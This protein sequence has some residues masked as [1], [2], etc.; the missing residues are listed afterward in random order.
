MDISQGKVF[1]SPEAGTY[2]G[3][4]IDVIDKPNVSTEWGLKNKVLIKWVITL[5]NGAPYLDPEGQ[6][7]TVSAYVT[8]MMSDRSS[9][10][11]F[12]NLYKIIVGILG[13]Q[14]PL[15]TSTQQLEQLLLNR[16][17]VLMV[18]KEPNPKKQGEFFVNVVGI[19]PMQAGLPVP[20]TPAGFVRSKDKPKTQAGPQGQPVQTY[21]QPPAQQNYVQPQQNGYTTQPQG[22]PAQQNVALPT[23]TVSL[24]PAPQPAGV[25][26]P[27]AGGPAPE[28]F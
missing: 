24:S 8:A 11:L 7:Y 19:L 20:Q 17:N 25:G 18:V 16:A 13:G 28:A 22:Q 2:L 12:R 14:P 4:I 10:P 21:A 9:Q 6:P 15:L 3:K 26:T 27:Q 1:Y 23:N 5:L